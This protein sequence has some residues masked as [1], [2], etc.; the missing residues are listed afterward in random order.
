MKSNYSKS[1]KARVVILVCKMSSYP[2]LHS[3]QVSSKYSKG[4]SCY[5][6]DTNSN[7]KRGDNFKSKKAKVVVLKR[8]MS[9]HPVLHFYQES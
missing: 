5:R 7:T 2:V 3:Y 8:D 6:V 9:P 4:Y 1:K